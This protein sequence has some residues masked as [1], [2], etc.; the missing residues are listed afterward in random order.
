MADGHCE[1]VE[2]LQPADAAQVCF[3][4]PLR[5]E[6]SNVTG[7]RR[8]PLTQCEG[9]N[10]MD[11]LPKTYPC[12]N[13]EDEWRNRRGTSGIALFFAIVIPIA[14]AA[15]I[16]YFVWLKFGDK[17]GSIR[18]GDGPSLYSSG[19]GGGGGDWTKYP[20]AAVSAVVAVV[21]ALPL[22]VGAAWRGV[23]SLFGGGYNGRTYTS[24]S[25]FARGRGDYAAVDADEGLLGEDSDEE[26]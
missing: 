20:V 24:R 10:V 2:G 13:H 17:L 23:R 25:S 4:D 15:G 9:G 14:A 19:R 6:Y 16:G 5:I 12:P 1:L 21:A 3:D 8:I 18:L 22:L 26:V 11:L 7:Y